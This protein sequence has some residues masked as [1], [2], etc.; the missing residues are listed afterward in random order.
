MKNRVEYFA[1]SFVAAIY[2]CNSFGLVGWRCSRLR[3][4]DV[5][6]VES[7]LALAFHAGFGFVYD[8]A[9]F[10][11]IIFFSQHY[12]RWFR[13]AVFRV[14]QVWVEWVL[15]RTQLDGSHDVEFDFDKSVLHRNQ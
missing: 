4:L 11:F 6:V 3:N 5:F 1:D 8:T 2:P 13:T 15:D 14:L 9:F 10:I 7:A 12:F